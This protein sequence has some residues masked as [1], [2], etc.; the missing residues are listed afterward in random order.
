MVP[1]FKAHVLLLLPEAH[2]NRCT[3]VNEGVVDQIHDGTTEGHRAN[4]GRQRRKIEVQG[5]GGIGGHELSDPLIEWAADQ[6]FAVSTTGVQKKLIDDPLKG[7]QITLPTLA[8]LRGKVLKRD[9]K[10]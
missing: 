8:V 1:D 9:A 6:R 4:A 7:I 3:A 2:N 5:I 10:A